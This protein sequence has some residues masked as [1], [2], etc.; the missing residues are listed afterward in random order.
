VQREGLAGLRA[1]LDQFWNDAL[2]NLKA[3]VDQTNQED[4]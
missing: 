2:S 3:L 1:Q 4:A